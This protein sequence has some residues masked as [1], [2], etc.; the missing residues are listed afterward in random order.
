MLCVP[1]LVDH[2]D[3]PPGRQDRAFLPS[4]D[5]AERL[6]PAKLEWAVGLLQD[7]SF[8]CSTAKNRRL[9]LPSIG[10]E[11]IGPGS[12]KV[13][14][15][16]EY[17]HQAFPY[18]LTPKRLSNGHRLRPVWPCKY[19]CARRLDA[20]AQF[21]LPSISSKLSRRLRQVLLAAVRFRQAPTF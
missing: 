8:R 7:R 1:V 17:V 21:H 18:G 14:F 15:E 4:A 6:T 3:C 19:A 9:S 5:M 11:G 2:I 13:A 10:D 20:N 12:L 16:V